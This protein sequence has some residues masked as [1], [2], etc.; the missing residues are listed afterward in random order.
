MLPG[1]QLWHTRVH[2]GQFEDAILKLA[3]NVRA[4]TPQGGRLTVRTENAGLDAAFCKVHPH[5]ESG[6][7]GDREARVA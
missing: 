5:H 4:A 2:A 1:A 6:A 3:I 7:C